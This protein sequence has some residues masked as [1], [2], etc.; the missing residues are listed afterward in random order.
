MRTTVT[1]QQ[2]IKKRKEQR[3]LNIRKITTKQKVI[4]QQEAKIRIEGNE[5]KM[6][7]KQRKLIKLKVL[8]LN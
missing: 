4:S 8:K 2:L 7:K 5:I 3:A 1:E 6:E